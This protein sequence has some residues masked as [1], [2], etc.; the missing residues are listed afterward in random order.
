MRII[1]AIMFLLLVFAAVQCGNGNGNDGVIDIDAAA[2]AD[3]DANVANY[4]GGHDAAGGAGNGNG[5]ETDRTAP[6][7]RGVAPQPGI[8]VLPLLQEGTGAGEE[9]S[10]DAGQPPGPDQPQVLVAEYD[11]G[12]CPDPGD[13]QGNTAPSL[14]EPLFE[15]NGWVYPDLSDVRNGDSVRILVP[16]QDA[17]CNL[18]CGTE[19]RSFSSPRTWSEGAH[20]LPSNIPCN[21]EA[22]DTYL[23]LF[24]DVPFFTSD[25]PD[26]YLG[27]IDV[28]QYSGWVEDICGSRSGA[29]DFNFEVAFD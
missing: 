6:R 4:A 9:L 11:D 17:E 8:A 14:G 12:D 27:R 16:F 21:T 26:T 7:P 24:V 2:D 5:N 29:I 10:P 28:Y 1:R 3:I 22:S 25:D 23:G 15:I 20:S 18:A 13:C 19:F